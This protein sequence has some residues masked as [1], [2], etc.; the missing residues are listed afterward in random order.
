MRST[1]HLNE[2]R[3]SLLLSALGIQDLRPRLSVK[4]NPPGYMNSR[5]SRRGNVHSLTLH[6]N[7]PALP[8]VPNPQRELDFIV[9]VDCPNHQRRIGGDSLMYHF[10]VLSDGAI[11]QTRDLDMIAW[12]CA[13]SL[14]NEGSLS[15]HLPLGIG[16][17]PTP[18]QWTRLCAL[19]DALIAT[20]ALPG[21]SVVFGHCDWPV[22]T[23]WAVCSPSYKLQPGQ[24]AC[25]GP[26]IYGM[27]TPKRNVPA[28]T[29]WTAKWPALIRQGPARKYPVCGMVAAG[30]IFVADEIKHG[31]D[32]ETVDGDNRW[33]H[34]ADG[35]GFSH[36]SNFILKP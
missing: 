17:T 7:G 36:I 8:F 1:H 33:L 3:M 35:L 27:L 26:I 5:R 31:G 14:G 15:I 19:V 13:N 24:S 6:Y 34:R 2:V 29:E 32:A 18:V 22:E 9:T 10:A 11:W 30:S 21:W 12:H 20:Y 28:T 23:G 4:P 16:Q 25:P